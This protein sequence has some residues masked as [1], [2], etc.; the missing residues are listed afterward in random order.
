MVERIRQALN[1]ENISVYSIR[2]T[3]TE[4]AELFYIKRDLDLRRMKRMECWEVSVYRD[5]EKDGKAMRGVSNV[6]IFPQMDQET[7][8]K[9]L[10]D[11][12]FAASFAGNPAYPLPGKEE[13]GMLSGEGEDNRPDTDRKTGE[14]DEEGERI[15]LTEIADRY[16]KA[17][18]QADCRTDAFINTAEFFVTRKQVAFQ[19]SE[20]ID[21]NYGKTDVSG[22]YVV[23]CK[24][25][26]DVEQYHDFSY[27][28]MDTDSLYREVTEALES[29]CSRAH[30]VAAPKSGAYDILLG[31]REIARLLSIYVE[32]ANLYMIYPGYSSYQVGDCVQGERITGEKLNLRLSSV[33]PYSIEGIRMNDIPFMEAG[34]LQNVHGNARFSHYMGVH[35]KGTFDRIQADNGSVS[36]AELKQRPYL[37]IESFSDF[38]VNPMN[39]FFGGEIRLAYLYDGERLTPVTG[40]SINGNLTEAQKNLIFSKERYRNRIYEGPAAVRITGVSVAGE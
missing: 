1:K 6:T 35:P 10:A 27:A 24:E 16:V 29:V 18:Y 20:G 25:P 21:V 32:R 17:L 4:S 33:E 34:V 22:E 9:K 13:A 2:Q 5:F 11:A 30:A 12:W 38:E 28:G 15:S 31:G 40:G 19:N 23:Q 3:V 39:G 26:Q 37:Q 7:V 14:P 36:L 8:Q